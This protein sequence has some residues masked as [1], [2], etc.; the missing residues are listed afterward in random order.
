MLFIA[1]DYCLESITL[2]KPS[3]KQEGMGVACPKWHY[4]EIQDNY[5][6]APQNFHKAQ[7][8]VVLS[9]AISHVAAEWK[10]SMTA[11]KWGRV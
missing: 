7:P 5:N 10:E 9:I 6:L 11:E 2:Q 8:K 3:A 1:H 4:K